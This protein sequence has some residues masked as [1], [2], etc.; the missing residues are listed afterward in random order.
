M[1]KKSVIIL[2]FF[3][4]NLNLYSQHSERINELTKNIEPIDS[5]IKVKKYKN[6][7]TKKI[8]NFIVYEYGEYN[9]EI[10][11]G[12]Q[13][14]FHKTGQLFFEQSYDN[15]GNLLYQKQINES[16]QTYKTIETNRISLK[17]DILIEELLSSN[18]NIIIESFEKEFNG[19]EENGE[20]KLWKEGKRK[21]GKKVGKWKI[22]NLCDDTFEIKEYKRK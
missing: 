13:Q 2:L 12:K 9:Y 10:L 16:G 22:Y 4:F 19:T 7:K 1:K 5:I 3:A 18:K 11:S 8:S 14:L 20:L 15:F 21:N 6:G 17:K